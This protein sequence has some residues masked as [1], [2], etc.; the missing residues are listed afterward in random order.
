MLK[1]VFKIYA[2]CDAV[3]CAVSF[4][5]LSDC[6]TQRNIESLATMTFNYL[7]KCGLEIVPI[8]AQS[9]DGAS[10]MSGKCEKF[11][12]FIKGLYYHSIYR[13]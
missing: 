10:V 9:Q 4:M 11:Q 3:W 2:I 6:F 13:H 12:A 5:A 1:I 8:L 7:R